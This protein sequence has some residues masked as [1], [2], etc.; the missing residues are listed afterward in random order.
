MEAK[1]RTEEI[2]VKVFWTILVCGTVVYLAWSAQRP[3]SA[4]AEASRSDAENATL[5]LLEPDVWLVD[6]LLGASFDHF[7]AD[8][9][10]LRESTVLAAR[11]G[12][13]EDALGDLEELVELNTCAPEYYVA[14]GLCW[15]ALGN[16]SNADRHFGFASDAGAPADLV[17]CLSERRANGY[18]GPPCEMPPSP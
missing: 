9:Q 13:I 8:E 5:R 7:P 14:Q 11:S 18:A 2:D 17:R 6:L 15:D 12:D 3:E 1:E 16:V 10:N 4:E